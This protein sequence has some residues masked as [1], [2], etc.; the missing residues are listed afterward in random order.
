MIAANVRG[1]M[2]ASGARRRMCLSTFPSRS[3]ISAN[4]RTRTR[5]D[6]IS[7][8]QARVGYGEENRVSGLLFERGPGLGLMQNALD[9][10][11]RLGAPRRADD[12]GAGG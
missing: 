10:R 1:E 5:P 8:I 11:E 4:D 7:S 3:A 12:G 2:N 6:A 9:G